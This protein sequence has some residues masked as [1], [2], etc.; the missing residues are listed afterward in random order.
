MEASYLA[1]NCAQVV[2]GLLDPSHT[3]ELM[4]KEYRILASS[5]KSPMTV[6]D[7]LLSPS[8]GLPDGETSGKRLSRPWS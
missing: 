3:N 7:A 1:D 2:L 6:I 4:E 5:C 8:L